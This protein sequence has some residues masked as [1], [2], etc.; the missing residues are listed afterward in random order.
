M[1]SGNDSKVLSQD[2]II[3]HFRAYRCFGQFLV[4]EERFPLHSEPHQQKSRAQL[5]HVNRHVMQTL[6]LQ[7]SSSQFLKIHQ[8]RRFQIL[9][10]CTSPIDSFLLQ[11]IEVYNPLY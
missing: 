2:S 10:T 5:A 9:H 4:R 6:E 11:V 3:A 8:A 7:V 1:Q